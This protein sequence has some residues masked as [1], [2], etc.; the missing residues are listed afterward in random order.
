[1]GKSIVT[2]KTEQMPEGITEH[3]YQERPEGIT[4]HRYQE[5][6][7]EMAVGAVTITNMA[8][9]IHMVGLAGKFLL[10]FCPRE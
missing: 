10:V 7:E 5:R 4:G 8:G 1:M 2:G 3:R 9:G 6:P